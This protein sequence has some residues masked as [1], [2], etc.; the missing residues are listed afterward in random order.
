MKKLFLALLWS[1]PLLGWAQ[2]LPPVIVSLTSSD[3]PIIVIDTHQQAI[4]D[5]TKIV[6]NMGVI[7]KGA[8]VRNNLTDAFNN[9]QGKIA[10]EL[11][12]SSSLY[13]PKESYSLTTQD[14]TGNNL[15]VSLLGLPA[16]NDWVLSAAYS[17]KT[18]LRNALTYGIARGARDYASR[19]HYCE[20]VLN[21]VYRGV[22]TFLEKIKVGPN[23]VAIS[24]LKPTDNTGDAV[25]GGYILKLDKTS[26]S[27]AASWI[28]KYQNPVDTMENRLLFQVDYPKLAD[29]TAQQRTYIEAYSDSFETALSTK[30]F[31]DART[32]YR[33]YINTAS[34]I[35]YFLLTELCHN[36]DGYCFSTYFYKDRASKGG[37]LTM[38]PM[39]DYDLAWGNANYCTSDSTAGWV[40]NGAYCS[41]HKIPF[42]W[43]QLL[44]DTTFTRELHTRWQ[45]L[46][47]T[48]LREDSLDQRLDANARQLQES[49][50]RNYTA[51]PILGAY[52]WPEPF[53][54]ATYQ[55]EVDY[56]KRWLHDRLSWMDNN[57]PPQA[58]KPTVVTSTQLPTPFAEATAFP[59]PFT[60]SLTVDYSL[61]SSAAVTVTLSD[62][63]GR[64]VY[65]QALAEQS[66]GSHHFSIPA[67]A[68]LPPGMYSL[69][70][71]AGAGSRVWRVARTAL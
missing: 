65:Q 45:S 68:S 19:T 69:R 59:V 35:D 9:Y 28:S 60:T 43:R 5:G 25:T 38:G 7:Y 23:R 70:L 14:S 64:L 31:A 47:S 27:P 50:A 63:L 26:G 39:W 42:W 66:A 55:E 51:W 17:D 22:Y 15:N 33:H 48:V 46:R 24:K 49:Q 58:P 54:F 53:V 71:T 2:T 61:P 11:R 13:Q 52:V 32:G 29:I 20:V 40:Y 8:G 10:I 21:G 36:V 34:F 56:V 4:V 37:K 1:M 62:V 41:G 16:E 3:L 57:L 44:T 6:A 30:P 18:M 12:G 67:G